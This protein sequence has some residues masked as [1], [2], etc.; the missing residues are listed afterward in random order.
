[1][2]HPF[3]LDADFES[4]GSCEVSREGDGRGSL[5][6]SDSCEKNVRGRMRLECERG[7]SENGHD[8]TTNESGHASGP[9]RL[10]TRSRGMLGGVMPSRLA[11]HAGGDAPPGFLDAFVA[12]AVAEAPPEMLNDALLS[13]D[14]GGAL[15][16]DAKARF[17]ITCAPRRARAC[18]ALLQPVMMVVT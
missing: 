14:G 5:R 4:D 3:S 15:T 17:S 1:L 13:D 18:S 11:E 8:S 10:T 6:G 7:G 9:A 12:A 2:R 16:L